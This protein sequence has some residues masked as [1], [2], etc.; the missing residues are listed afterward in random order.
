MLT[1]MFC[2]IAFYKHY[3]RAWDVVNISVD[4]LWILFRVRHL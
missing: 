1:M 4:K 3:R 2:Y